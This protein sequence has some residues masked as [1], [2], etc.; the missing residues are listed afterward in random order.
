MS[1]FFQ[2]LCKDLRQ[3]FT[4]NFETCMVHTFWI[5]FF[6]KE[7]LA[8]GPILMKN[9]TKVAKMASFEIPYVVPLDYA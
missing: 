7:L 6:R 1:H 9:E 8:Y 3:D 4:W 5:D 2:Q